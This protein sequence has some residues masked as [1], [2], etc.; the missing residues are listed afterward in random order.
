[1]S[2]NAL[3]GKSVL[4]T[5]AARGIGAAIAEAV[6][7]AGGAVALLD[8]DPEGADTA[9][10]LAEGGTAHFFPCDV[11]S[12][13]Q[14]DRA[15]ADA[16]DALGGLHGLVNNAGVNAYFDAVAM[17]EADWDSVF[18]VDLKAAWMLARAAL[19]TLIERRGAIVN[20]SSIQA[21]L[22]LRGFF[23]YA[24][25]KAGLEGLTR[26]LALEYAS[27]GVRVNAVAP[28]YTDTHLVQ[29]W[30]G[31]QDDPVATLQSVLANIPLGRMATPRE[32]GDVVA[33]LLSDQASAI[34]GA[35]LAVD[36][37]TGARFA[38]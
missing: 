36:C 16:Q 20:I 23:P 27:A 11:R 13:E 35:T 17:T 18:A 2:S 14:V 22:T 21:R 26:S 4:V 28:G 33:F 32:I 10:R 38:T 3:E 5:G 30:L 15:V 29:E 37:G 1:M 9:R 24:A 6:V 12:L 31:L 7:E 34:T 8:I 19:P 25:A